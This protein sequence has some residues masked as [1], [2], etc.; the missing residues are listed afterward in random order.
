MATTEATKRDD[1][2]TQV[3]AAMWAVIE[4]HQP[5][6]DMIKP[7][8][9]LKRMGDEDKSKPAAQD[10]DLPLLDI[11]P[12]DIDGP[13]L[14][15]SSHAVQIAQGFTIE[16]ATG[17]KDETA[18]LFPIK[19][20]LFR[21]FAKVHDTDLGLDFVKRVDVQGVTEDPSDADRNRGRA[22]WSAVMAV[23][24]VMMFDRQTQMIDDADAIE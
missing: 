23:L 14:H 6:A 20:E 17:T 2:F 1:P 10:A 21:A 22:G 5:L 11:R 19:W 13:E 12:A 8:N 7:G 4:D 16:L 18:R 15:A 24:V 3:L 9:R